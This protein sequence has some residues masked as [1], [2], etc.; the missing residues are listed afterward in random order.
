VNVIFLDSQVTIRTPEIACFALLT[1]AP[2]MSTAITLLERKVSSDNVTDPSRCSVYLP[3]TGWRFI[4]SVSPVRRNI[5]SPTH[6]EPI[7]PA[8]TSG[9]ETLRPDSSI[10]GVYLSHRGIAMITPSLSRTSFQV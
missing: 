5:E 10:A 3:R 1:Q 6:P 4:P 2:I 9:H 7:R 8:A